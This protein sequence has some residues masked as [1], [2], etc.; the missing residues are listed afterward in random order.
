MYTRTQYSALLKSPFSLSPPLRTLSLRSR[1]LSRTAACHRMTTSTSRP[2]R[3]ASTTIPRRITLMAQDEVRPADRSP[4]PNKSSF[5][6]TRAFLGGSANG[7][8]PRLIVAVMVII[9]LYSSYHSYFSPADMPQEKYHSLAQFATKKIAIIEV[10]GAIMEGEDSFAEKQIDRVREDPDAVV[11]VVLRVNSPGGTVTGS[12]FIYHHLRELVEKRKLP[13]V[14]SMGSVCASG[15]YYVAMAVGSRAERDLRRAHHL[16]RLD[17]RDHSPF[18]CFG[19]PGEARHFGRLDRQRPAQEDGL[20]HPADDARPRKRFCRRSSTTA[21]KTS[22]RSSS[23]AGRSSKTTPPRSDAVAT[24]QIFTA[25]QALDK[26]LVDKIGFIEAAIARATELAGENPRSV[27]C[28]KYEK[29]PTFFGSI[30]G[31]ESQCTGPRHGRL[32]ALIDLASPR[33]YYF[34]SWLPTIFSTSK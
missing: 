20:A 30:L 21:S 18:R 22:R 6:R 16:D 7:S 3:A 34:W 14:V 10:S 33:A 29:R 31:G 28:V 13:I 19:R 12:D 17:R 26:G 15:G 4:P 8:S 1:G 2:N 32:S 5:S 24:G 11:G 9:G 27:R 23:A 25:K